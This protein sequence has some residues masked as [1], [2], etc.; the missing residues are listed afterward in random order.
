MAKQGEI[1]YLR[2]LS[3]EG[4]RHAV[5]K[6]F[7]DAD[8]ARY[9]QEIGVI[10]S[11]LPSPP[12]RLLDVGCGTGWTSLFF[13]RRGY[14][15]VGLDISEDMIYQANQL[16]EQEKLD[17]L[18]FVVGDY[19]VLDLFDGEFDAAVFYDS[20]HHA[21]NE[22]DAL[23]MVCQALKPGGVCLA[24][25]PGLGHARSEE[26]REAVRKYNVT[27]KDM[28]PGRIIAAGKRAG[29]REFKVYPHAY[30]LGEIAYQGRG[31]WFRALADCWE[32]ARRL[33]K[34]LRLA[35]LLLLDLRRAGLVVMVK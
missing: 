16:G 3:E 7:S 35:K 12:A 30:H 32:W 2:N 14:H 24:S 1:D 18:T 6:P 26:A 28:P 34:A 19:E 25:E 8:C 22:D 23:R 10:L 31:K 15:V 29:F 4:V 33:E 5:G 13:A 20:L 17:N 27:E 21:V 11:L 9:L